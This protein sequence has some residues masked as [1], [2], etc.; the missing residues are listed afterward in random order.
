MLNFQAFIDKKEREAK[1]QLKIIEHILTS[2]GF[3]VKD[4]LDDDDP[5]LFVYNPQKNTFFDGIRVYKI[6][7]NLAFRVQ[8]QE[9]TEP[10]GSAYDLPIEDMFTDL[11]T[12]YKPHEAGKKIIQA[13][14]T[15]VKKFFTKS[16]QAEKE[17]RDKEFER[18]GDPFGKVVV[19]SSDYGMDYSNLTYMKA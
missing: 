9:K 6:G 7:S 15:E 3:K 14:T 19:R 10:F 12:D 17:L 4:H 1:K 16:S 11:I 5:F 18:T 13:V 2:N 8:K